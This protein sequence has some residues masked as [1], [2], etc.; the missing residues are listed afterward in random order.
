[1]V[2]QKSACIA[3]MYQELPFLDRFQAA[4][5]DGFSYVEF[6]NWEDLDLSAIR[7]AAERAG[8]GIAAFNGDA[9]YSLINPAHKNAYLKFLYRSAQAAQFL[10]ARSLTIHSNALGPGGAV[11]DLCQDLSPTVKLLTLY[12]GLCGCARIAEETGIRMNLEPLNTVTD[13]PGNFLISSR[14]AAELTEQVGS[15]LLN[16]LFDVYHM[17]L[18]EGDLCGHLRSCGSRLGHIHVADVPGRHEPGTGEINY[19]QI[20][21]CLEEMGYQ[22]LIGFE[23][24]PKDSTQK[25]VQAILQY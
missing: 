23:L 24:Y 13:H 21:A 12:D 18:Q 25:A 20:F 9:A 3:C 2:F 11:T 1:M 17:Q 19:H 15:P 6:W 7:D 5:R 8:V 10:G 4:A 22:G 16:V 14:T